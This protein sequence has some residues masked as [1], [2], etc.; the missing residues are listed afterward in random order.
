MITHIVES[1]Q[2]YLLV[3]KTI[4]DLFASIT[5]KRLSLGILRRLSFKIMD[6]KHE[7]AEPWCWYSPTCHEPEDKESIEIFP[8]LNIN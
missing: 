4:Y 3:L 7:I 1:S 8:H 5:N 2:N 6:M